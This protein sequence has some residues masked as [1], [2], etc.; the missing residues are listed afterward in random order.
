MTSCKSRSKFPG[1]MQRAKLTSVTVLTLGLKRK[2]SEIS[3]CARARSACITF[4]I[5]F[6][7]YRIILGNNQ[8]I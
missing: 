5:F 3:D 8:F 4:F 7:I 6:P 1:Q 2:F